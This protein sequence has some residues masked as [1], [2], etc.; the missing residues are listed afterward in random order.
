MQGEEGSG[1]IGEKLWHQLLKMYGINDFF[2]QINC[3]RL[4]HTPCRI[5]GFYTL[6]VAKKNLCM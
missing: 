6:H 1:E 3:F 5:Y 2:C 4:A